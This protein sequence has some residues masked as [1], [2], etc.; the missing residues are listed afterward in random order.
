MRLDGIEHSEQ[1]YSSI[2]RQRIPRLI[3]EQARKDWVLWYYSTQRP[4]EWKKCSKCGKSKPMHPYFFGKNTTK[5][6]YYSACKCCRNQIVK[7]E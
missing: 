4:T 1:Y 3:A 6:G 5:D 7:E 2:W